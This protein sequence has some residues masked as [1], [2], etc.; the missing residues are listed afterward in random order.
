[1]WGMC[2]ERWSARRRSFGK[3]PGYEGGIQGARVG[4]MAVWKGT[5]FK[6]T[7]TSRQEAMGISSGANI[8]ITVVCLTGLLPLQIAALFIFLECQSSVL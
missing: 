8:W 7:S 3:R 2:W 4:F 6:G 1:M 5:R